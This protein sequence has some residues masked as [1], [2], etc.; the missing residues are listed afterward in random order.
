MSKEELKEYLAEIIELER[1]RYEVSLAITKLK[2]R[3]IPMNM[4]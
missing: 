3:G 1:K 2:K 4:L